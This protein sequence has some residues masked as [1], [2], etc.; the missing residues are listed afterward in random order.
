MTDVFS[1]PKL[2]TNRVASDVISRAK[3][4]QFI[5][6]GAGKISASGTHPWTASSVTLIP[7]ENRKYAVNVLDQAVI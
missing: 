7:L 6:G 2:A 5:S 1:R 4:E 3:L